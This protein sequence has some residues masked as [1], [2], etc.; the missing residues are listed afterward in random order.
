M[1]KYYLFAA[2][3]TGV[4]GFCN[5]STGSGSKVELDCP[6]GY[7]VNATLTYFYDVGKTSRAR[8]L[9]MACAIC[10]LDSVADNLEICV[11]KGVWNSTSRWKERGASNH[12]TSS[13][14]NFV[15]SVK[16]YAPCDGDHG[17]CRDGDDSVTFS[18][19]ANEDEPIQ[20]T[21]RHD[22]SSKA[23]VSN[24]ILAS[25]SKLLSSNV[26]QFV[27]FRCLKTY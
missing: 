10:S 25:P 27:N 12:Q 22:G 3:S 11:D 1:L 26:H 5:A 7:R 23:N 13:I 20:F 9:T 2:V 14:Y 24:G 16:L 15:T 6:P 21:R 18:A 4:I 19:M 8:N 17:K